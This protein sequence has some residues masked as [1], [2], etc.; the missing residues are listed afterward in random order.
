M[1]KIKGFINETIVYGFANVFSRVFAMLLIP[2]YA[3]YLGK[4][5]YSNLVMLQSIFTILTFLLALNSGVFFYYYEFENTKY[6]KIVFTS[7]FY[8]EL[9]LSLFFVF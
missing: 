5:D 7:W 3:N 2:F 6:R 4:I 8:Y 1:S 9:V